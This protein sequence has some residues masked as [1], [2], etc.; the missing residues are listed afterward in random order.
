LQRSGR[1]GGAAKRMVDQDAVIVSRYRNLPFAP[2]FLAYG[3]RGGRTDRVAYGFGQQQGVGSLCLRLSVWFFVRLRQAVS[4][5]G[6]CA[7]SVP[8]PGP[9]GRDRARRHGCLNSTEE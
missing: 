3:P 4:A 1:G 6:A 8:M 2:S 7:R 9:S 5:G